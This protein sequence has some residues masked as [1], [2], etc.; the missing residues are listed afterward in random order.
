M[1]GAKHPGSPA[2]E[3]ETGSAADHLNDQIKDALAQLHAI[4]DG[5]D[6]GTVQVAAYQA[7]VHVVALAMHN[8]VA[9]QQHA[10]ILRMAMTTSAANAILA[11]RKEEAEKVL[12]LAR[13][14]LVSPDLSVILGHVRSF[15]ETVGRELHPK[16][17]DA[18]Q[19][20]E[21]APS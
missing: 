6:Q 16:K 10:H 2:P 18:A 12:E 11:G 9:E 21:Q 3:R 17:H 4:L 14:S 1:A 7:F 19:A 8:A 13:S 20:A 5:A 15:V